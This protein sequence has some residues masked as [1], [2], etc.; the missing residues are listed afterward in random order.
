MPATRTQGQIGWWPG[1]RSDVELR[2]ERKTRWGPGARDV[3]RTGNTGHQGSQAPRPHR[4]K[5]GY[6][7]TRAGEKRGR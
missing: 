1:R 7:E 5:P 6:V 4:W 2:G 3:M